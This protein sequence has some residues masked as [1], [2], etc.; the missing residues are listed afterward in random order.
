MDVS[1]FVLN[2]VSGGIVGVFA[3]FVAS[4]YFLKHNNKNHRPVIR[5]SDK[6]IKTERDDGTPALIIKVINETDQ[7]IADVIFEVEGVN[8]LSPAGSIPLLN[9]TL[10]GRREIL[11]IQKF[12]KN[13]TNA[14]YAH[15][16][17]L[18]KTSGNIIQ[19]CEKY[20]VIRVSIRATC[21]Y[22]GTSVITSKDYNSSDDI[23]NKNHSFNTGNSLSCSAH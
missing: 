22:Y 17:K 2:I 16:T 9:L 3:S 14:H 1:S 10:L 12:D 6:L 23:L 13:D 21:P 11:Y 19:E 8:N 20:E 4:I 18:F 5:I 15:R 7:D